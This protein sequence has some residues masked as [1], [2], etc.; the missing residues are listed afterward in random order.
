[1]RYGLSQIKERLT[2]FKAGN[3]SCEDLPRPGRPPL[4]LGDQLESFRQKSPVWQCQGSGTA[5]LHECFHSK[6]GSTEGPGHEQ[7]PS[8]LGAA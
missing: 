4:V 1:M 8:T 7:I 6:A 3:L 2:R 5:V